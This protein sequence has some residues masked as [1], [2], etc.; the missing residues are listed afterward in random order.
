MVRSLIVTRAAAM[1]TALSVWLGGIGIAAT[2]ALEV[3][4]PVLKVELSNAT[5]SNASFRAIEQAVYAQINQYRRTQGLSPLTLDERISQQARSHSQ[6][7][8][9]Q[10]RL[11]HDGFDERLDALE[12]VISYRSGSE[13]VAYNQGF[14]DPA[15]RAV[16]GWLN[17]PGHRENIEGQFNLTGIGVARSSRG[18]YYL[19]Q[20][21]LA[22]SSR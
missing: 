21:L 2:P 19:T 10:R 22:T 13:N 14:S 1:G 18:E 16:M 7:M 5:P 4:A 3:P 8:A 15:R 20:I 17:S 12:Q 6:V 11:S 9:Q